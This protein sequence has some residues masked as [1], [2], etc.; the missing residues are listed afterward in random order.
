MVYGITDGD[1]LKVRCGD[2]EQV[3]IRLDGIDAPEKKMPFG[4]RSKES[5]SDL[6]F[7]E[8][9][10]VTPD[11]SH[12]CGRMVAALRCR[13]QDVG[14]HQ[15]KAGMAWRYVKYGRDAAVQAAEV[16]TGAGRVGLRVDVGAMPTWVFWHT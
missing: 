13:G 7:Q 14:M 2:G 3:K 6:C 15:V 12:S 16:R 5:L 1:T 11:K 4:Q 10:L 9:A 8:Q